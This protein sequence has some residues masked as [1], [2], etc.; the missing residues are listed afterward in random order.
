M[1]RKSVKENIRRIYEQRADN[2]KHHFE[3]R[4]QIKTMSEDT[5]NTY[6]HAAGHLQTPKLSVFGATDYTRDEGAVLIQL[7]NQIGSRDPW[8]INPWYTSEAG[9]KAL[10]EAWDNLPEPVDFLTSK[11]ELSTVQNESTT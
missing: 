2:Y 9:W 6:A 10:Q 5:R 11:R 3:C 1:P 4:L 8:L 7:A